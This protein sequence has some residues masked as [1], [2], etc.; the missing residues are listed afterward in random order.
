MSKTTI[1]IAA[2][3]AAAGSAQAG[4]STSI[5]E[6]SYLDA[7]TQEVTSWSISEDQGTWVNGQYHWAFEQ[8]DGDPQTW[9]AITNSLGEEVFRVGSA[10]VDYNVDPVVNVNFNVQATASNG[11]YSINSAL[12][13]FASINSAIGSASAAVTVTDTN[14]DGATLAVSGDRGQGYS[15]YFNGGSPGNGSVFADL[16][17]SNIIAAPLSSASVSEDYLGGGYHPVGGNVFDMSAQWTFTLTAGD[18]ASGTSTYEIVPAPASL[19]MLGLGGL[20]A[21]RRRR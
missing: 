20:A 11:I 14:F 7:G 10:S 18:T 17:S 12:N 8:G 4:L 6:I 21:T 1:G 5:I 19:A 3:V 2:L 9:M 13:T 16:L 15:A